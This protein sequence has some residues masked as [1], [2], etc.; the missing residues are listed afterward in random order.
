FD[1]GRMYFEPIASFAYLNSSVDGG[2]YGGADVDFDN[3]T[4]IRGGLGARAGGS[5]ATGSGTTELSVLGKVW[6]EFED[7]NSV[8]LTD[9]NT[10]DSQSFVDDISG[11]FGEVA[12]TVTYYNADRSFSGF[13]GGGVKFNSDFTTVNAQ[14]GLRK[15]F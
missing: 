4:S 12:G 14:A 15:R 2:N 5:F 3:G 6:N 1:M 7:E 13:I 8:T 10:L 11:V 9:N